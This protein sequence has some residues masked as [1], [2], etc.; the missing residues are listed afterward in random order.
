MK[1][2]LIVVDVQNDFCPGGSLAV[3]Y[4]DEV[5]ALLNLM[6][7]HARKRNMGIWASL[8]W[9]PRKTSHFA[10]FNLDGR[11]WPVHCVKG[12][13]GADFHPDLDFA[14]S[15]IVWKGTKKDEDAY[16]AFQGMT[17]IGFGTRGRSLEKSLKNYGVNAL[18]I[19]GLA[20]D[21]CVEATALDALKL[22][23][24]VYLLEDACRAVNIKPDDGKKAIEEMKKAGAIITSVKE[25]LRK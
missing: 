9:H 3:P 18:Y 14:G 8:E 1:S 4:G 23:F 2:A 25:V 21:Y 13:I 10:K 17:N 20:T 24:K 12:T 11:G 7:E 22:G 6:V 15:I 16:S 19:G 5:V